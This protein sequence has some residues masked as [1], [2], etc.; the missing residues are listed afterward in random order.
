[1]ETSW[2]KIPEWLACLLEG[3]LGIGAERKVPLGPAT[4]QCAL[5]EA[6]VWDPRGWCHLL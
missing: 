4:E 2:S 6:E 5:S 3:G 1:M